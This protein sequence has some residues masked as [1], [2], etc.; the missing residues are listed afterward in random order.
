MA[1]INKQDTNGTKGTLAEGEFGY[2]K[3]GTDRG[4]VYVGTNS[5]NVALATKNDITLIEGITATTEEINKLDGFTGTNSDLNYA[6]DL[7]ATGV[8]T[9]E[10]DYLDGVTANIQTQLNNKSPLGTYD[11]SINTSGAA[12]L[13][14]LTIVNGMVTKAD[15]RNITASDI[16]LAKSIPDEIRTGTND[17]KFVTPYGISQTNFGINQTWQVPTR[18]ANVVYQNTTGKA[19]MISLNGYDGMIVYLSANASTWIQF[20]PSTSDSGPISL[21]VPNNWYYKSTAVPSRWNELR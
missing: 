13:D 6:K 8:T 16:G 9:T 15:T 2:D 3:Q 1:F 21:V 17:E 10:F 19:I 7:R 18:I 5:G 11:A 14:E 20:L 12:V 4:R